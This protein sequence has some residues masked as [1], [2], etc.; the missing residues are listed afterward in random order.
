MSLGTGNNVRR[1]CHEESKGRARLTRCLTQVSPSEALIFRLDLR[2]LDGF[3]SA[4]EREIV[5]SFFFRHLRLDRDERLQMHAELAKVNPVTLK[6]EIMPL[7]LENPLFEWGLERGVEQGRQE[8]ELGL[9]LRLLNRRFGPIGPEREAL[10]GQLPLERLEEMG[11][12]ILSI[13]TVN[14]LDQWLRPD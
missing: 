14:E 2:P 13:Q 3:A 6:Q 7:I 1:G 12:A 10:I 11:E 5:M 9:L 8:G 4:E